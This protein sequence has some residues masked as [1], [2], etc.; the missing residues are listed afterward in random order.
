MLITTAIISNELLK[1]VITSTNTGNRLKKDGFSLILYPLK[2]NKKTV[3]K[4][5]SNT[6]NTNPKTEYITIGYPL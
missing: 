5:E 6:T 1:N 3:A 2:F 4:T